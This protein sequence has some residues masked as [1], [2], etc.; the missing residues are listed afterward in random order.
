MNDVSLEKRNSSDQID[1][2]TAGLMKVDCCLL[3]TIVSFCFKMVYAVS[4]GFALRGL[5][6]VR[7]KLS[8]PLPMTFFQ[9]LMHKS[10]KSCTTCPDTFIVWDSGAAFNI[11][12]C[13]FFNTFSIDIHTVYLYVSFIGILHYES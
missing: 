1:E 2:L 4:S 10:L 9:L 7:K 3:K 6:P 8:F 12:Y 13:F 5:R 11:D